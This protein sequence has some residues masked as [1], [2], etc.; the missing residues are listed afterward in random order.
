MINEVAGGSIVTPGLTS[1]KEEVHWAGRMVRIT[2]IYGF[3]PARE[4]C[5]ANP[6]LK[7]WIANLLTTARTS[8]SCHCGFIP[9]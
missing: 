2:S 3:L 5:Q 7:R 4:R 1:T 8:D 9:G 6:E